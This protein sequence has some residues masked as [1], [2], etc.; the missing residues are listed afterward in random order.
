MRLGPE[1]TDNGLVFTTE[2]GTPLDPRNVKRVLDGL[3]KT[4]KLPHRRI[5][6]LRHACATLLLAQ[7]EDLKMISEILGHSSISV[8]ADIYAHVSES[9][10]AAAMDRLDDA[11]GR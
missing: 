5:H 4:A 8:T 10:V 2:F 11:I 6:D 7:G 3:L 9:S 1:W